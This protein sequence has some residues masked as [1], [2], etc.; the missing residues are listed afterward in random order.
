MNGGTFYFRDFYKLQDTTLTNQPK[1]DTLTTKIENQQIRDSVIN[2]NLQSKK[3]GPKQPVQISVRKDTLIN[4]RNKTTKIQPTTISDREN[5]IIPKTRQK[6]S[7]T[8]PH[9]IT[10]NSLDEF[11]QFLYRH[12]KNFKIDQDS[13]GYDSLQLTNVNIQNEN[14]HFIHRNGI[15]TDWIFWTYIILA[16]LFVWIQVFYRKYLL[17]LFNSI[18]SFQASSKLFNEKNILARRVSVVLNFVYTISISLIIFKITQYYKLKPTI[19]DKLSFFLLI[20]NFMI[21]FSILKSLIQ[22]LIGYIFDRLNQINEYLHN[23]YVFN[24]SLG[25]VIIPLSFASFYTQNRISET[26]FII[27]AGIYILSLFLKIIRGFQIILKHDIFI[28][29]SILYLCTLEILP[30]LIGYK[31]IKTLS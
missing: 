13:A 14:S 5:E 17:K 2:Q 29:Y 7:I 28:L 19:F 31:F 26:L 10:W 23:V 4:S 11:A 24:K 25:I 30:V 21:I 27:V 18:F 16:F 8:N 15:H 20:L 6:D 22:K 12:E 1:T 3:A 9:K